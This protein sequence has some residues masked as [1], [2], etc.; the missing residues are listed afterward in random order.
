MLSK[1]EGYKMKQEDYMNQGKEL[2]KKINSKANLRNKGLNVILNKIGNVRIPL[3]YVPVEY[4]E[5]GEITKSLLKMLSSAGKPPD[6]YSF[7][8]LNKENLNKIAEQK[9]RKNNVVAT[10]L[11]KSSTFSNL[12]RNVQRS[13]L[14]EA[15]SSMKGV[16]L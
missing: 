13:I 16:K 12:N 5:R 6:F 4:T 11:R 1:P 9:K 7:K 10:L 3:L 2:K 14:N 8:R 15:F